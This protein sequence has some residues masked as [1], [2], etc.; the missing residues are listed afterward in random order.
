MSEPRE[1]RDPKQPFEPYVE[2]PDEFRMWA[3]A[4]LAR[5]DQLHADADRKRQEMEFAPRLY[6][7]EVW[8]MALTG[9]AAGAG[10]FA[11]GAAF[12]KLIGG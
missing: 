5:I 10:L 11:A 12:V 7:V 9:M 8:R 3:R 6:R 2:T 1:P 4:E